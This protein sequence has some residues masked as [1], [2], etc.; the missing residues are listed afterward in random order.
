MQSCSSSAG[1]AQLSEAIRWIFCFGLPLNEWLFRNHV[2]R[3]SAAVVAHSVLMLSPWV[4]C[5][6]SQLTPWGRRQKVPKI[7]VA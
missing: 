6:S 4:T 5:E 3:V 7:Q 1:T 2:G